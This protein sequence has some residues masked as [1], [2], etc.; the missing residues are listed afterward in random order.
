MGILDALDTGTGALRAQSLRLDVH[1]KNVANVDTPNYVR[2]IPILSSTNQL[3]FGSSVGSAI[4]GVAT[5]KGGV[6]FSGVM[7]DPNLGEKIYKPGHPDADENGFIRASNVDPSVEMADAILAQRA[8]EANLALVNV[9]R[10]MAMKA[11]DIGR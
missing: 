3:G 7:E 2:L 8:Y 6:T 11:A 4:N 5:L 1:A 9:T 10:A